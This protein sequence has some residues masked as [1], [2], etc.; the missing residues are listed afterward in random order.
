[1]N[2]V[3][4]LHT[5]DLHLC[6]PLSALGELAEIRQAELLDTFGEIVDLAKKECVEVIIISGDLFDS[7]KPSATSINYIN[8]KLAQ[9]PE[10]KVF[11]ALGNHD[12]GLDITLHENAHIFGNSVERLEFDGYDV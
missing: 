11:I 4:I 3:K 6:S 5:A 1:M 7:P 8:K 10:I 2:K 9:I 12:A